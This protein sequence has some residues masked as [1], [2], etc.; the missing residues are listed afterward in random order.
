[1]RRRARQTFL[2]LL[3]LYLV[4]WLPAMCMIRH[5]RKVYAP[6]VYPVLPFLVLSCDRQP[7]LA[8][9]WTFYAA[10]GVGLRKLFVIC[11]WIT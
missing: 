3:G 10:Y 1:M 6:R 5:A 11:R 8:G 9:E 7:S 4:T 2:I